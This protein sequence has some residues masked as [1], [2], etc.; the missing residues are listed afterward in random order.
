MTKRMFQLMVVV[1]ILVTSFAS[2]GGASAW[3]CGSYVTVQWGD[4]LSGIAVQCGTTVAA[5]QAANPGLGWWVYAGQVLYIPTGYTSA[6]VYYPTYGTYVVQWGD[7]LGK[8]AA[9]TGC[10]VYDILAVNP[11]IRNASLIY[12][13]QVINLPSGFS[14]PPPVYNPPPQHDDDDY[15]YPL[16]PV[17][18]YSSVNIAYKYGLYVRS[19]P[20]GDIIAS[21]LNGTTWR[22]RQSSIFID[23]R[24][25]IWAEVR[26][27][28]PV[29]GYS[30]GWILVKD[31]L[32]TYFTDPPI[33]P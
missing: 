18:S 21:A 26:L 17:D 28:P 20:G 11:Q 1:A 19:A 9:R 12:A 23:S 5:I 32:G 22:Y 3:S 29:K 8:I 25:K 6:P 16:P 13:G 7:T 24:W 14:A 31:Q 2:A 30:T 27:I 4:T 10:G 33:D 15:D